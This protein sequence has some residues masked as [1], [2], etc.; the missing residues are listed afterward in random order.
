[1]NRREPEIL[2][3]VTCEVMATL[4]DDLES[5]VK[6][7]CGREAGHAGAHEARSE[8]GL[9]VTWVDGVED[10]WIGLRQRKLVGLEDDGECEHDW[11]ADRRRT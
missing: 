1:M 11:R 9:R 8:G 4:H 6:I 10:I 3:G 5:G 7:G 2:T